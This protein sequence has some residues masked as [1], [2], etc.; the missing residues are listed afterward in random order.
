MMRHLGVAVCL[1]VAA[2]PLVT[3]AEESKPT[4]TIVI[5]CVDPR[6]GEPQHLTK[7]P[8]GFH[9]TCAGCSKCLRED[10]NFRESFLRQIKLLEAHGAHIRTIYV[11]DH[12]TCKAYGDAD[13]RT[14]HENNL[15]AAAALLRK[16]GTYQIVLLVH[17]MDTQ[18]LIPV[19][20]KA[21]P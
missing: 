9:F 20:E 13:S 15:Q 3:A 11:I 7:V 10:Q 12:L 14:N 8:R 18:E 17:D 6:Y 1:L 19:K 5:T 21:A 4:E 2:W 16:V